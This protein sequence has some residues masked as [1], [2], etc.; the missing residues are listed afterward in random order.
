MKKA[1]LVGIFSLFLLSNIYADTVTL[2]SGQEF[3]GKIIEKTDKA[4]T[5][6]FEGIQLTYYLDEVDKINGEELVPV[7]KETILSQQSD[8]TG[9]GVGGTA[10]EET[11]LTVQ[12]VTQALLPG[13]EE[14]AIP[15]LPQ[16]STS[17]ETGEPGLASGTVA[18]VI[19]LS[20][21]AGYV[22]FSICLQLIAKKTGNGPVWM[23]WVPIAS[24]F[25]MCKI[26]KLS[27]AWMLTCFCGL[28]PFIGVLLSL[29][30]FAFFWYRIAL[31]IN[32]PGWMGICC[33]VPVVN[34]VILCYFAF[35]D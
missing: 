5:V 8:G 34:V 30:F 17:I 22:L 7:V 21:L 33:V 16:K 24:L 28:I 2:K 10:V 12:P 19:V 9:Q 4:L 3:T 29:G 20:F 1:I 32:K 6:E 14:G 13:G 26:A 27:P 23:A 18:L 11:E 35:T 31:A 15:G 25:L